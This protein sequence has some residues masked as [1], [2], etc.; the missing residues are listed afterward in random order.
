MPEIKIKVRDK[1]AEGEGV[2]ICNNSDYTVVWDLDS[3]WE[4]YSTRTMRVNLADGTYQDAVFTGNSAPLPVLT[5]SG[6]VSVGLYAGDLHT[7]RAARLLALSSV[8]TPVGSP[9][10]PAEDVY[11]QIMAKLNE[12][13]TVSPEDIA[14]A[15]EDYLAEHPIE[16]TDPTVPEWAKADITG[17]TVGQI[18]KI[19]AVDAS[20]V[21]TAWE[22]VEDPTALGTQNNPRY[23]VI[24]LAVRLGHYYTTDGVTLKMAVNAGVPESWDDATYFEEAT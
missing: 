2:I 10:A 13:S 7:S 6:W 14:K 20:G 12:L 16:E 8:L 11:A 17:A 5:A 22:L 1:C 18:A 9:A 3:E 21:P 24:G 4:P 15:V 23:W 19:A